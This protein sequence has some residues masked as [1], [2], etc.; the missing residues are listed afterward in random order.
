MDE[1]RHGHREREQAR[2]SRGT[3]PD[4]SWGC[5]S[6]GV[7]GVRLTTIKKK[8]KLINQVQLP[9]VGLDRVER[10]RLPGTNVMEGNAEI[11][12]QG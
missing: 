8:E 5:V 1:E 2:D 3:H 10:E 4:E 6:K 9:V 7:D 12:K 11:C